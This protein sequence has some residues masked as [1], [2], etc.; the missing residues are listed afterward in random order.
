MDAPVIYSYSAA[1]GRYIGSDTA[2]PNPLEPG[3]WLYP[4]NATTVA[5]PSPGA[6]QAA[7]FAN[8]AWSLAPDFIGQTFYAANG[9][10]VVI[11][12]LGD[13]T[14]Q[15]LSATPPG[16]PPP[17]APPTQ[18]MLAEQLA[19]AASAACAKVV[20]QIF[21]DP[22]HQAAFQNAASIVN[23][24]GGAAPT[25]DPLATKFAALAAVYGLSAS[26]FAT[27]VM[28]MQGASFDLS[29]ALAAL[30][31]AADAATT[32]AALATALA[33]FETAIATVVAEINAAG[34]PASIASPA[35]IS[36]AGI[37]A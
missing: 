29:A 33:A 18:A 13:P 21:P 37:N 35:P 26:A 27:L 11:A 23:G 17:P 12:A 32:S 22:T 3:A 5:P 16:A 9:A 34:L 19:A 10:P 2:D 6:N 8:G 15:G 28:A 36:I 14:A 1:D 20:A 24:A 31:A 30:D 4:A 25:A 7:V